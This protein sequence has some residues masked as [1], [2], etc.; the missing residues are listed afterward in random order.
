MHQHPWPLR[1]FDAREPIISV[2]AVTLQESPTAAMQESLGMFAASSRR[3][4]EQH[5]RR[6]SA[7][8]S[9]I[10]GSNRPKEPLLCLPAPRIEDRR[11][12]F[13]HEETVSCRQIHAHTISDRLQMEARSACPGTQCPRTHPDTRPRVAPV[14][15]LQPPPV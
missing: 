15:P 8:M 7:T 1:A 3:V 4:A 14:L 6:T 9:T 10:I 11:R 13:V 12:G 5:N 2:I